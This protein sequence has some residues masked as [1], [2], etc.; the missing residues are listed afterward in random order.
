VDVFVRDRQEGRTERVSIGPRGREANDNSYTGAISPDG[1]FVTFSSPATNLV[2][3][4]TN[5][6]RDVFVRTR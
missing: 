4:D 2:P 5:D 1:R 3:D 6:E